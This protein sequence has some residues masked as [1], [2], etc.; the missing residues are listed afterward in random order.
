MSQIRAWLEAEGLGKYAEAFAAQDIS[1]DLLPDLSEADLLKLGVASLGDRKRL[2]K[3]I[4]IGRSTIAATSAAGP[5]REPDTTSGPAR[6]P[7]PKPRAA[8]W[9][10]DA[11]PLSCSRLPPSATPHVP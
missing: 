4:A 6:P 11:M 1:V 7:F 5:R 9:V 8:I 2:L 3:A 10:S